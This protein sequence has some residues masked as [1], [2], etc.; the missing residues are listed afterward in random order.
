M[1]SVNVS[2]VIKARSEGMTGRKRARQLGSRHE[3]ERSLCVSFLTFRRR[4]SGPL[5]PHLP[6]A[7]DA[8]D[9]HLSVGILGRLWPRPLRV[10]ARAAARLLR[11]LHRR[12]HSAV[13]CSVLFSRYFL[14]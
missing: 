4:R 2:M 10:G 5:A 14:Q 13:F 8:G 3:A 11:G 7:L 1:Y 12:C 9:V 6:R